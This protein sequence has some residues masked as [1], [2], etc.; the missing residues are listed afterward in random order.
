[1]NEIDLITGESTSSLTRSKTDASVVRVGKAEI[2]ADEQYW[3]A[4]RA[5][6]GKL[7]V[8]QKI[9]DRLI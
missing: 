7:S 8:W 6:R 5:A 2:D 3:E 1:L 4:K 9:G